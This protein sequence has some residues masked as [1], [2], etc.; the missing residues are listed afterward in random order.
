MHTILVADDSVTIQRAVEI[1]FDKEP[2]TVVK[3]GSADE[4]LARARQ[5]K[6]HVILADHTMPDRSGYDLAAALR[7][8]PT[9]QSIPVVLL[10]AAT[11]PFD[12]ARAGA[13]GVEQHVQ[14]PFDCQTL[15]DRVRGILGVAATAPGTAVVPAAT[16]VVTAASAGMPRP[17]GIAGVPRPPAGAATMGSTLSATAA[18]ASVARTPS[19]PQPA[20]APQAFASAPPRPAAPPPQASPAPSQAVP[21]QAA[22]SQAAPSQAAPS[23]A[24]PPQPAPSQPA[25]SQPSAPPPQAFASVPPQP[26]PSQP[27]APPPQA[28]ASVPPQPAP[29]LQAFAPTMGTGLAG[30][31]VV[32]P[33]TVAA[34]APSNWQAVAPGA[35][36]RDVAGVPASEDLIELADADFGDIAAA[37]AVP[38]ASLHP[39][40]TVP[41]LAPSA[42]PAAAAAPGASRPATAAP[43]AAPPSMAPAAALPV[44]TGATAA[45]IAAA[46]PAITAATGVAPTAATLSA[47]ARAIVERIAWEVVPELA[48]VIIR[49]EIQRLLKARHS[50]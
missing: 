7:A 31:P 20:A 14:K 26:A 12:A 3:A 45:V 49:E 29:P 50:G 33:T 5:L 16:P 1:A 18:A 28:F 15:L 25:P 37:A 17:P 19:L 30:A 21:S 48:E 6:P 47:E 27:S 43:V 9:T 35:V 32:A 41:P 8:D 10:T 34:S 40:H 4:A 38:P 13:V 36:L 44:A 42:A 46:G 11:A 39:V 2:F 24:V 22:P 23:Q